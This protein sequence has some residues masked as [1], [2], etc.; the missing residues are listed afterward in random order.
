MC[1]T[2]PFVYSSLASFLVD[3]LQV[4]IGR[5]QNEKKN[6]VKNLFENYS[7][8]S[9]GADVRWCWILEMSGNSRT[10]RRDFWNPNKEPVHFTDLLLLKKWPELKG[11]SGKLCVF[12]AVH[13]KGVWVD[14]SRKSLVLTLT[15]GMCNNIIIIFSCSNSIK[16]VQFCRTNYYYYYFCLLS[17]EKKTIMILTDIT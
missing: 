4:F 2:S 12:E 9:F 11:V 8:S 13:A 15:C 16:A 5:E 14:V 10:T 6:R 3:N 1:V 17:E 7:R